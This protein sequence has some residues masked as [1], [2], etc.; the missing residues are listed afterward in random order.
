MNEEKRIQYWKDYA[1]VQGKLERRFLPVI[2]KVLSN[3]I[4]SFTDRLLSRGIH[5]E[6]DIQRV[7][8]EEM[9]VVLISLHVYS[10][11]VY[12]TIVYKSLKNTK[13]AGN[14]GY[15]E[16]WT[17]Q[18]LS[19]FKDH[20]VRYVKNITETTRKQIL[21]KLSEGIE[22]G[23]GADKIARLLKVDGLSKMRALR[24]V[25]TE[26][27]RATNYANF[28]ASGE[29]DFV[30]KKQWIAAHDQRTRGQKK[31]DNASHI[32]MDGQEQELEEHFIDPVNLDHL[33]YPGDP[34]ASAAS[35]INCRCAMGMIPQ[36]DRDGGL[37]EKPKDEPLIFPPER[38][39]IPNPERVRPGLQPEIIVPEIIPIKPEP[40]YEPIY[41]EPFKED[42]SDLI[43]DI[44]RGVAIGF[45][46]ANLMG[47]SDV[48]K[49]FVKEIFNGIGLES[50]VSV[51]FENEN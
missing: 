29:L 9:A 33:L 13:R 7:R 32:A 37:I 16:N 23:Y 5:L 10:A 48:I 17:R 51:L 49:T 3:Q 2:N 35:T 36:R 21:A 25:R 18:V 22:K 47:I 39:P 43:M 42:I 14:M 11:I 40:E 26:T 45:T 38:Q 12:G 4:S 28:L 8:G 24:I 31:G 1:K 30:V 27:V 6:S 34:D 15:N 41:L 46:A 19:Y 44:V 20:N 50:L